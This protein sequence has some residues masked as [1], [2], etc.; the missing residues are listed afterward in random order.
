MEARAYT[1]SSLHSKKDN[2]G[3]CA[4]GFFGAS[5]QIKTARRSLGG[6]R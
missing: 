5:K 1:L 2:R 3:L 4:N 6:R